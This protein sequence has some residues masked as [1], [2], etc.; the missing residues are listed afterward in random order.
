VDARFYQKWD[1]SSQIRR[2]PTARLRLR[3]SMVKTWGAR[4]RLRRSV[5]KTWGARLRLRW[6][7]VCT[8]PDVRLGHGRVAGMSLAAIAR[9][10]PGVGAI[11]LAALPLLLCGLPG[12]CTQS[13][14]ALGEQCLKDQD[15]QSGI[16][17]QLQCAAAPALLDGAVNG[18]SSDAGGPEGAAPS[19]APASDAVPSDAMPSA[20]AASNA[21]AESGAASDAPV[22][23]AAEAGGADASESAPPG[24]DALPDDSAAVPESTPTSD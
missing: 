19:D 22:E 17:S 18:P 10:R 16:C 14:R 24:D 5:V 4:L 23:S 7:V 15:C 1:C 6:S 12:A 20:D 21:A 3:R 11:A 8:R 2:T 13:Q 9:A